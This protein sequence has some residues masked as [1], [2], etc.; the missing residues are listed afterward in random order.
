MLDPSIP[1]QSCMIGENDFGNINLN[2]YLFQVARFLV[3][4]VLENL[5]EN[6]REKTLKRAQFPKRVF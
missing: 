3:F 2:N 6:I 1:S 4:Q 5:P